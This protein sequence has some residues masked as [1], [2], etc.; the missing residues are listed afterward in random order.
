MCVCV[1]LCMCMCLCVWVR[2]RDRERDC[3]GIIEMLGFGNI[4][5]SVKMRKKK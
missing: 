5:V 1:C 4:N 3:T 2:E